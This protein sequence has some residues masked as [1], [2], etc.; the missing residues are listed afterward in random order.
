MNKTH[1]DVWNNC[2]VIIKDI[3]PSISFKTWFEPIVPL[4][5]ENNILTIQVPSP[6]FYEYLEEQYNEHPDYGGMYFH[7][8]ARLVIDSSN[9]D[10]IA[11]KPF[12]RYAVLHEIGHHQWW[13]HIKS[14]DAKRWVEAWEEDRIGTVVKDFQHPEK[15]LR[16]VE[17]PQTTRDGKY[18]V[19]DISTGKIESLEYDR[20]T[21]IHSPSQYSNANASEGFAE[22]YAKYRLGKLHADEFP[23]LYKFFSEVF[24]VRRMEKKRQSKKIPIGEPVKTLAESVADINLKTKQILSDLRAT[25]PD[26]IKLGKDIAKKEIL[27]GD[28]FYVLTN[29]KGKKEYIPDATIAKVLLDTDESKRI[30]DLRKKE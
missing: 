13:Y 7:D 20:I 14:E 11:D 23:E 10:F 16:I 27:A 17:T 5:L 6:F 25:Q 9:E 3:I 15:N 22:A 29:K 30:H 28:L 19:E 1:H 24:D 18:R 4:K 2:L 12:K 8:I 21:G 26:E